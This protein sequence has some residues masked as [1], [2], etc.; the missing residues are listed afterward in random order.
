MVSSIDVVVDHRDAIIPVVL[1]IFVDVYPSEERRN[2]EIIEESM[3]F[4]KMI[5]ASNE[6]ILSLKSYSLP[7]NCS[8][9]MEKF[10]DDL[11]EDDSDDVKVSTMACGH[12]FH[13]NCIVQ[14]LQTSHVCP[15]CRY[16]MPT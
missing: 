13:Y 9:C 12:I 2:Q 1:N 3:Q 7:Q 15:L 4:V 14:W 16:A 8:I 5:P 6:A 10:H 11:K